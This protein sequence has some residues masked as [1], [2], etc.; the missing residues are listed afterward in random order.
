MLGFK[1]EVENT[2]I[3]ETA[4]KNGLLVVPA[5]QYCQIITTLNNSERRYHSFSTY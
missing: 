4:L 2:F 5:A 3:A 1:C